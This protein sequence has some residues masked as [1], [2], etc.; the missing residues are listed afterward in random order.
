VILL[1]GIP[2]EP[3]LAMVRD[4]LARQ[5]V[6]VVQFNQR[7]FAT[8]E[9]ELGICGSSVSGRLSGDGRTWRLQDIRGVFLRLMDDRQL[10]E[11]AGL[12]GD[13]PAVRHCRGLHDTLMRWCEVTSARVVNRL[14]AMGS[15]SSKAYQMQIIAEH[16]FNV[17][18]TLITSDPEAVHEFRRRHGKIVYKSISGVRSIV[19]QLSDGDLARLADIRWCPTQFQAYVEGSDVRVHVVD[20]HVFATRIESTATDYRYAHQQVDEAA[21]LEAI[22]LPAGAAD[23]CV[24]LVRGLGLAFAGVDLRIG[25]DGEVTCFEVNPCP[26]FSYYEQQTG[27]PIAAAVA[28]YLA[29]ERR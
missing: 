25:P 4:A 17:P 2:S 6:P 22:E 23:A 21:R 11:V 5:R 24:R 20:R 18:E 8:W 13:A 3:P 16:G 12:A 28:A 14:A 19:Q 15:N 27:Q 26:A 10:P 29:G 7:A 1:C 9:L